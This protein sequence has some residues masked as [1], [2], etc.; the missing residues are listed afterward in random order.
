MFK[1]DSVTGVQ[2]WGTLQRVN[3]VVKHDVI[4]FFLV[5]TLPRF[6]KANKR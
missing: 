5:R 4:C 6:Q 3:P 2:V 1:E